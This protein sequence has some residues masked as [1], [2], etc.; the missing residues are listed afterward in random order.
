MK[1]IFTLIVLIGLALG[2]Y[3]QMPVVG[4]GEYKNHAQQNFESG[5]RV[6]C[7][8]AEKL[9]DGPDKKYPVLYLL[10]GGGGSHI[11]WPKKAG[12]LM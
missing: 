5:T 2:A 11:D 6:R 7:L 1:Q 12:W 10:H 3:A 9:Y 4:K 8:S